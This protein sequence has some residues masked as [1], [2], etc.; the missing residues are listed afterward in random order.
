MDGPTA[1]FS[2][3]PVYPGAACV[4]KNEWASLA[5][6]PNRILHLIL[7]CL[8]FMSSA[9]RNDRD[10]ASRETLRYSLLNCRLYRDQV[11]NIY[12]RSSEITDDPGIRQDVYIGSVWSDSFAPDVTRYLRDVVDTST[13]RELGHGYY[14]DTNHIYFHFARSDGGS[15][16]IV[17]GAH[18]PTFRVLSYYYT[19]DSFH[20]Y[21]RG[22]LLS[23]ADARTF[24]AP[25]AVR[26]DTTIETV[27][28]LG[29]DRYH[30]FDGEDSLSED[31]V[32]ERRIELNSR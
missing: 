22:G 29:R 13:F 19:V 7:I 23:E 14:T 28:W 24:V 17:D 3:T 15:L 21:S 8:L 10:R 2:I 5:T 16:F 31:E 9:C 11:G 25:L 20:V 4:E 12:F 30:Y 1:F 26:I 18:K 32:L 6:M 27:P